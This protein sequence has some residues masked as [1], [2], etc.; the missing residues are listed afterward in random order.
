MKIFF[1]ENKWTRSPYMLL[2]KIKKFLKSKRLKKV[3]PIIVKKIYMVFE[4]IGIEYFYDYGSLLGI[5][6]EEHF[7]YGDNDIDVGVILKS[8]SD[9]SKIYDSLKEHGFNYVCSFFYN[10]E[11]KEITFSYKGINVDFFIYDYDYNSQ[12]MAHYYFS[13]QSEKKYITWNTKDARRYTYSLQ[14]DFIYKEVYG[15][16]CKIMKNYE[17]ALEE[18]YGNWCVP[19]QSD[20]NY[21]DVRNVEIFE[22][23][24]RVDYS[25]K[26]LAKEVK[27]N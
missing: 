3:A 23:A 12:S 13:R 22:G 21:E 27:S 8:Q 26:K 15:V 17:K 18:R 24:A 10:E 11:I 6:R 1:Y 2:G 20:N 19:Q 7:L 14:S 4:N 25:Y 16:F 9:I 5:I